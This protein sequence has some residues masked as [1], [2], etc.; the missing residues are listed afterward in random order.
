MAGGSAGA[1]LENVHLIGATI[2]IKDS[3][4]KVRKSISSIENSIRNY[5]IKSATIN[6]TEMA[7][8]EMASIE[9]SATY[10]SY[11]SDDVSVTSKRLRDV[12]CADKTSDGCKKAKGSSN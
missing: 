6:W 1:G 8:G 10:A 7:N 3:A 9:M 5:D 2:M 11:Y 4:T 12:I